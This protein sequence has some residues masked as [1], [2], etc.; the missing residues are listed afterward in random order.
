MPRSLVALAA[1]ASLLAGCLATPQL[2]DKVEIGN[3]TLSQIPPDKISLVRITAE[4]AAVAVLN[5]EH[6]TG[7]PDLDIDWTDGHCVLLAWLER[8]PMSFDPDPGSSAVYMV[9]LIDGS[10]SRVNWVLVDASTG[11]VS[12]SIGAPLKAGCDGPAVRETKDVT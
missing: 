5:H 1:L 11:E 3:G 4:A 7:W 8:H 12:T 10:R 9:R 6:E 2:H